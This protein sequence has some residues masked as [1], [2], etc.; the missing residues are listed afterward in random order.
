MICFL[1]CC[2]QG[3]GGQRLC[4]GTLSGRNLALGHRRHRLHHALPQ[5]VHGRRL[6]VSRNAWKK[7]SLLFLDTMDCRDQNVVSVLYFM[8]VFVGVKVD[9]GS[10]ITTLSVSGIF[11]IVTQCSHRILQNVNVTFR[12]FCRYVKDKRPTISPNFNFLGQLLEFEKQLKQ[13]AAEEA[14][15][16]T[17]AAH[18]RQCIAELRSPTS[19]TVATPKFLLRPKVDSTSVQSPTTALAKLTFGQAGTPE[20]PTGPQEGELPF[21][22]IPTTSLDQL[23]FTPCFATTQ[24]PP[25]RLTGLAAPPPRS[26]GG[27][28]KRPLSMSI[29]ET[30]S[31]G[32]ASSQQHEQTVPMDTSSPGVVVAPSGS[33]SGNSSAPP[34]AR[35]VTLRSSENKAKRPTVRPNSIA[36]S[37]FPKFD[38]NAPS[39]SIS[40]SSGRAGGVAAAAPPPSLS[41]DTIPTVSSTISSAEASVTS[42][43]PST[44]ASLAS[45][46]TAT[47][48]LS[49]PSTLSVASASQQTSASG[50]TPTTAPPRGG[51]AG[52]TRSSSASRAE[53]E[54]AATSS[55]GAKSSKN[56][57]GSGAE[58]HHS[59]STPSNM[60][61]AR[62]LEQGR[63]SRS[64]ED[65]LNSP[66]E[67]PASTDCG[68]IGNFG[69]PKS[70][71][72]TLNAADLFSQP[73]TLE[74]VRCRGPSDPHQSSSSIS[75]SGSH[76]SLHG[77]LEIIQVS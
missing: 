73:V 36:F 70:R 44:D 20:N 30:K 26:S 66:D 57:S 42:P 39:S 50:A 1:Y 54:D 6:Q 48:F 65:I 41:S 74:N 58:M 2:R 18:K 40:G 75:S 28:T 59:T 76:N 4:D 37:S 56:S 61:G 72:R 35:P 19:P 47:S 34:P 29:M 16:E 7:V 21:P 43:L 46:S 45:L 25:M 32:A 64:M 49:S 5:H 12:V 15:P 22:Q 52:Q 62:N 9:E 51:V 55:G 77:S 31:S 69:W 71:Q 24:E 11:C 27:G 14:L 53:G 3:A 17:A 23:S 33:S 67:E 68:C 63:K 38:F 8:H 60:S 10:G 13:K